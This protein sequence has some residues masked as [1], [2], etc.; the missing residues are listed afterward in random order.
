MDDAISAENIRLKRAYEPPAASDGKRI[1]VDRLWPRG[2]KKA[3]AAI[4]M[5]AKDI[6]PSTEL[7]QWFGHETGRW[8][9]FRRRYVAE[10]AR[11]TDLINELRA[12]ARN[13]PITLVFG[14][15][16]QTHNDAVVLR[17]VLLNT[18]MRR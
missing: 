7:R 18:A 1:L 15:H 6:A 14:A 17:K 9:E 3:A 16:D 13:R 10:L 12:L 2:V 4:D 11:K 5:W 8:D